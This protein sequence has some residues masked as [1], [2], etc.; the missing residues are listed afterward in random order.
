MCQL[1]RLAQ[2]G[3]A[4]ENPAAR[5]PQPQPGMSRRGACAQDAGGASQEGCY[6]K[7][8]GTEVTR[9]VFARFRFQGLSHA[10]LHAFRVPQ[11][12]V[13]F[14]K[15][16]PLKRSK[17]ISFISNKMVFTE[18]TINCLLDQSSGVF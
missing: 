13:N 7:R 17:Q 15:K 1:P 8:D 16:V 12:P 2:A 5:R 10:E 9:R 3:S 6:L 4:R 11:T 14:K 18:C